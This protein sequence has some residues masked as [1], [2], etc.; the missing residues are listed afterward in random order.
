MALN[1]F[2]KIFLK[3]FG[4]YLIWQMLEIL[5]SFFFVL[6]YAGSQD[7]VTVFTTIAGIVFIVLVLF[8][9]VRQFLF[10]SD[11]IIEKLRLEKG[12]IEEKIE[13]TIHRSSLLTIII[14]VLGGL[15]LADGLPLLIYHIFNF[16][17]RADAYTKFQDNHAT[18]YLVT[19]LVKVALG[20]FMVVDSKM[21]VNL[22]ERKRRKNAIIIDKSLPED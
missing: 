8:A 14:I 22:I 13:I 18:P 21:I 3:I 11:Y 15:M 17:Q 19:N 6:V 1:T 9:V 5:P 12:F 10:K 4:L 2:W 20:Y 7:K 16:I